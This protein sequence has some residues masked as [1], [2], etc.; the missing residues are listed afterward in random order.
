MTAA[1]DRPTQR[2]RHWTA[3][4]WIVLAI[5]IPASFLLFTV[6]RDAV[7]S[8]ARLRFERQAADTHAVIENRLHPYAGILYGLR[9]LFASESPV[10]RLQFHRYVESLDLKHRYPGF[11]A[12]NF[13]MHVRVKDKRRFEEAVRRDTS[14]DPR[15]YPQFTIKPPGERPEYFV[16]VYLEPT[17]GFEFAFGLDVSVNPAQVADPKVIAAVQHYARDSGK[18]TASGVPIR[19]KTAHIQYTG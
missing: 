16:I 7:E 5:G 15:G 3:L 11:D 19:V 2:A 12:L 10:S 13:A 6:I 1:T 17:A 9:A 4:P 14:L 8:V 18:L